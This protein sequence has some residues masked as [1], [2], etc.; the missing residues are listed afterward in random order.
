MDET[1]YSREIISIENKKAII[2]THKNGKM[3]KALAKGC[4]YLPEVNKIFHKKFDSFK[5]K[6][7][8]LNEGKNQEKNPISTQTIVK[9]TTESS[10]TEVKYNKK[11]SKKHGRKEEKKNN[12]L[13]SL[14]E[15]FYII[16]DELMSFYKD[17]CLLNYGKEVFVSEIRNTFIKMCQ[18]IFKFS[19]DEGCF[20]IKERIKEK[21]NE[22]GFI[23]LERTLSCDNQ[24]EEFYLYQDIFN[25][26]NDIN[27]LTRYMENFPSD[28]AIPE[29]M[30]RNVLED[31]NKIK[32]S[33]IIDLIK[34]LFSCKS[35]KAELDFLR[36]CNIDI[37]CNLKFS[38]DNRND[39][40][41][42]YNNSSDEWDNKARFYWNV[43]GNL[44]RQDAD[45][46]SEIIHSKCVEKLI[47]HET[48]DMLIEKS[49][50]L[51]NSDVTNGLYQTMVG[52]L[53][54]Q[55]DGEKLEKITSAKI[56]YKNKLMTMDINVDFAAN[57]AKSLW[58]RRESTLEESEK[59]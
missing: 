22:I 36:N 9:H 16:E 58:R 8:K 7:R 28:K 1:K 47:L 39:A 40:F 53:L 31:N 56:N 57:G 23:L 13:K 2:K 38:A 48:E 44:N 52:I 4:N 20:G 24:L 54:S 17:F 14:E 37:I 42:W 59:L 3:K 55:L 6:Y 11:T 15:K 41:N 5:N 49:V 10:E 50:E 25:L 43:I 33:L 46:V 32:V 45:E 21:L 35:S 29:K 26:V 51:M 27:I 34:K 30:I 19:N 12:R 18:D